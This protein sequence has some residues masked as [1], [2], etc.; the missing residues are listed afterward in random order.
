MNPYSKIKL[1]RAYSQI[2]NCHNCDAPTLPITGIGVRSDSHF[3]TTYLSPICL[4]Q[5]LS[6][7]SS[8]PP[9]CLCLTAMCWPW[10]KQPGSNAA[11]SQPRNITLQ[12]GST[13]CMH[14]YLLL[15]MTGLSAVG[16]RVNEGAQF[17]IKIIPITQVKF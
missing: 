4:S 16:V 8:S 15:E 14:I 2:T 13:I 5:P 11:L 12:D 17:I 3:T 7:V 6:L 1:L 9:A 10:F